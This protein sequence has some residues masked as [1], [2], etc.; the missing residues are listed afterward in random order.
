MKVAKKNIGPCRE[1]LKITVPAER[2]AAE[3]AE[4][5]NWYAKGAAVPG[6]RKGRAPKA[7]VERRYAK[8]IAEDLKDRAIPKFYHEALEQENIK[9]VAVVDASEPKLEEGRPLEFEVTI[10]VPPEFKLPKY[11]GIPLKAE[12]TDVTERQVN[13]MLES[14]R[15]QHATFEDITG[16]AADQGDM[17]QVSYEAAIDGKPLEDVI[18]TAKGMGRG[19]GYWIT[20]ND[21]SFLPGMGK[22]LIK[23]EIGDKKEVPVKFPA[24]FIVKEL[25]GKKAEY[26]VEVTGMRETRLPELNEEFFNRIRVANEDEL[27]KNIRAHLEEAAQSRENARRQN[28]VCEF[29]LKKT[30]LDVPESDVK[31]QTRMLVYDITRQRL[32]NG[33]SREQVEEKRDELL[34]EAEGKADEQVKLRY[35]TMTIADAENIHVA[36]QE[37]SD[38]I[39]RMAVRQRRDAAEYRKQLEKDD[40]LEDVRDQIRFGKVLDH[41]LANAKVK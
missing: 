34:K 6:F 20:C 28:E 16:R 41:L 25:A 33:M 3:R 22:A 4:L 40:Q 10:D 18:P 27:R 39:V 32:M 24:D 26:T 2:V 8:E 15:R 30:K 5:L 36:D 7:L 12:S 35:I 29:L 21:E 1:L 14:I 11:Q 31:Q 9:V 37:V 38:E 23:S 13:E 17:V 19:T